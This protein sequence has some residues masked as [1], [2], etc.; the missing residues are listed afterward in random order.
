MSLISHIIS[1]WRARGEAA[2]HSGLLSPQFISAV[3][4]RYVESISRE[5]VGDETNIFIL[6]DWTS[7][8]YRIR[9]YSSYNRFEVPS[10]RS[11]LYQCQCQ[12]SQQYD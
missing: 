11:I 8:S 2:G 6:T 5:S 4:R 10:N 7:K 1:F 3:D 9:R 12:N